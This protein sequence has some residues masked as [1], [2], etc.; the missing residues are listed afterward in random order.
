M[1]AMVPFVYDIPTRV[2]FGENQLTHLGQELSRFG[3]SVL[4]VYGG[5]SIRKTGL[6][7]TVMSAIRESGLHAAELSGVEPN[8]KVDSV[9]RGVELC[10]END[11]DVILA[12]G[13]GSVLDCG[14]YISAAVFHDGDPWD[15]IEKNMPTPKTLPVVTIVTMA[16]TGSEMDTVAVISNMEKKLKIGFNRP[17]LRPAVSFLDPTLTYSVSRYQTACGCA[18]I[19]SH[20]V[21]TYFNDKGMYM[22]DRFF[23]GIM[24]TVVKYASVA[25]E[26][27]DD[28]EARANIMWAASWAINGLGRIMQPYAWSCHGLEHQLSAFYDITHGLGLAILTPRW[29]EHILSEDT[30]P[31]LRDLGVSVFDVDPGLPLMDGA[32]AAIEATKKWL[33]ETLG[34]ASTLTEIGIGDEHIPEMAH[35]AVTLGLKRA[36]IPLTDQDAEDIFRASL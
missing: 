23:E 15:L 26:K 21:E 7:D 13:G 34:L 30:A 16:A 5:G 28:Y 10:R 32:K 35:S 17:Q 27:P 3:K 8:P 14:K 31:R 22:V 20:A 6:Y 2:Y 24:R 25:M 1:S 36:F 29:M 11:V 33:F 18:D 19:F 12:V 4:F 9:R